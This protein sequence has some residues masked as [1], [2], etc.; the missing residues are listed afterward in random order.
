MWVILYVI[1]LFVHPFSKLSLKTCHIS[2]TGLCWTCSWERDT[3]GS[4]PCGGPWKIYQSF[5]HSEM[6]TVAWGIQGAN[7]YLWLFTKCYW[8]CL[9][10]TSRI[11][12]LLLIQ[13]T[14]VFLQ[15]RLHDLSCFLTGLLVP[16]YHATSLAS[17]KSLSH[18]AARKN[19]QE[20]N[21]SSCNFL[22]YSILSPIVFQHTWRL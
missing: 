20:Q 5:R 3:Y 7:S 22:V 13:N 19:I 15:A 8:F 18:P 11:C 2:G 4:S 9:L 10:N 17:L 16:I 14:L 12:C 6:R 1:Q 21:T